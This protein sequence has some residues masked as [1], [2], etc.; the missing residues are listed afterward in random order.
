MYRGVCTE[1]APNQNSMYCCD[2]PAEVEHCSTIAQ[3]ASR[4]AP[5]KRSCLQV[6]MCTLPSCLCGT[7]RP[8]YTQPHEGAPEGAISCCQALSRV[9]LDLQA[10]RHNHSGSYNKSSYPTTHTG[11]PLDRRTKAESQHTRGLPKSHTDCQI[12]L[13]YISWDFFQFDIC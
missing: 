7:N 12:F 2:G 8:T 3:S 5:E 11:G 1:L 10:R 4:E 6:S 9:R 13:T